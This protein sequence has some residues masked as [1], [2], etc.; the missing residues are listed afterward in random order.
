MRQ[1]VADDRVYLAEWFM[2]DRRAV[3]ESKKYRSAERG[4]APSDQRL[5][6]ATTGVRR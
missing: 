2:A 3:A 6:S 1:V 5:I 4:V